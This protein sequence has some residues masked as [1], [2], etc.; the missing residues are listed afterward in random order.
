[1]SINHPSLGLQ[2][3]ALERNL[4]HRQAVVVSRSRQ[5]SRSVPPGSESGA[6]IPASIY[7]VLNS[8]RLRRDV[9]LPITG[10]GTATAR[11]DTS[12]PPRPIVR[13]GGGNRATARRIVGPGLERR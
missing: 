3:L 4:L 12:A 7:A 6:S 10:H 13:G 8:I 2:T 11:G 1:M 9:R 5:A